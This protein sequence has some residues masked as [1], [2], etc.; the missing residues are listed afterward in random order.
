MRSV[1]PWIAAAFANRDEAIENIRKI[2]PWTRGVYLAKTALPKT[3]ETVAL[4]ERWL[5]SLAELDA[6]SE[7]F[8][9]EDDGPG[10]TLEE[11]EGTLR[12]SDDE[13]S[14]RMQEKLRE[15]SAWW[16]IGTSLL[17]ELFVVG[18]AALVFRRRDH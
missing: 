5:I 4:L 7:S 10:P 1:S 17:F 18:L 12:V 8:A 3:Q 15:R 6:L 13:V 11:T 14:R 2:E 9:G 16:V